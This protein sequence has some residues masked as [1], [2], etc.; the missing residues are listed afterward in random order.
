MLFGFGIGDMAQQWAHPMNPPSDPANII[1]T[2][3]PVPLPLVSSSVS[4]VLAQDPVSGE[5]FSVPVG[6]GPSFQITSSGNTVWFD[7]KGKP[8]SDPS[9]YNASV[10]GPGDTGT[11]VVAQAGS[12]TT[13]VNPVKTSNPSAPAATWLPGISNQ[14]AMIAGGILVGAVILGSIGGKRR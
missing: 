14:A 5:V 1:V 3:Q 13:G 8:I 9:A 7:T 4:T 2:D 10:V 6:Q 11:P 12:P